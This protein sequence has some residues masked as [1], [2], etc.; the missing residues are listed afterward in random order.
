MPARRCLVLPPRL[1]VRRREVRMAP[2]MSSIASM[3]SEEHPLPVPK[4]TDWTSCCIA[5]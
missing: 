4:L 5:E 1:F 3:S 2:I